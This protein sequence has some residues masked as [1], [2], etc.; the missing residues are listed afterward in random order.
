MFTSWAR[1]RRLEPPRRRAVTPCSWGTAPKGLLG[2][3]FYTPGPARQVLE[4]HVSAHHH[5]G[6]GI[7]YQCN[8]EYKF[9]SNCR[10]IETTLRVF[11]EKIC[12]K[13]QKKCFL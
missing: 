3:I 12:N 2:R 8:V 7:T 4:R 10:I 5:I 11:M 6:T 9:S 1:A 13:N